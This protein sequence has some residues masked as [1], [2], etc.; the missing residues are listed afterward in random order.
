MWADLNITV[1]DAFLA[2]AFRILSDYVRERDRQDRGLSDEQ[3]L[4]LGVTR[5]LEGEE[6]GR[7][8][9]QALADRPEEDLAVARSTW[10]DALKSE[11]RLKVLQEVATQSYRHFEREL[12]GRDW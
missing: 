11:R 9:L 1:D 3:F 4:R 2:P 12:A 5:A 6:S 8:F 7:A 10:F